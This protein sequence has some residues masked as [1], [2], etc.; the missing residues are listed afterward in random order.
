MQ[1]IWVG[2][3]REYFCEGRWTGRNRLNGF[4]KL[5]FMRN[6]RSRIKI[7]IEKPGDLILRSGHAGKYTLPA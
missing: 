6:G 3:E 5:D 2:R 4:R 7:T 1:V